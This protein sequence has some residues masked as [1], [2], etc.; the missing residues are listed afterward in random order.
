MTGTFGGALEAR[1]IPASDGRLTSTAVGEVEVDGKVLVLRRVHITYRL[2][3]DEDADRAAVDRAYEAHPPRCPVY[4]SIN[5]Q[6]E[7]TTDL[8]LDDA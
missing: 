2:R 1:S 7:V 6:I 3:L 5:P 8:E 4:R